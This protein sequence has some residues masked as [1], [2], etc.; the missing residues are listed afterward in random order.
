MN[1]IV[2]MFALWAALVG[3]AVPGGQGKHEMLRIG[4]SGGMSEE[5]PGP[6]EKSALETLKRFIKD[7]TG[8]ENE[9]L[10]QSDWRE[11]TEKLAKGQLQ[12]GV[13]EGYEFAWAQA[14]NPE[15]K[16][17]A[18]AVNVE[19]Y[20]VVF[21]ITQKTSKTKENRRIRRLRRP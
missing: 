7:E 10:R 11:L 1:R 5:T 14:N 20:A 3:Q 15:L 13:Y 4:I 18:L 2:F 6:K 21:V 8:L 9:I 17:L 16:P 12:V 19:H